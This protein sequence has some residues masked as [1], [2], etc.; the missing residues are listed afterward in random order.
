[1]HVDDAMRGEVEAAINASLRYVDPQ[2]RRDP[3]ETVKE[4]IREYRNA[5]GLPGR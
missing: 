5:A 3:D 4:L 1:M 2:E